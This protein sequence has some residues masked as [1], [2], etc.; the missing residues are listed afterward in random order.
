MIIQVLKKIRKTSSL[1]VK[2]DCEKWYF[3]KMDGEWF[4]LKENISK[5]SALRVS[6]SR[7]PDA[8]SADLITNTRTTQSFLS[9]AQF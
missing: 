4:C 5:D 3:G 9:C 8:S 1:V 6:M 2:D 7:L